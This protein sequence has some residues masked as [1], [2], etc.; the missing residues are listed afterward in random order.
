MNIALD[1]IAYL[2]GYFIGSVAL[3][4]LVGACIRRGG[5]TS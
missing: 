2:V 4:M 5:S 3:A 1:I